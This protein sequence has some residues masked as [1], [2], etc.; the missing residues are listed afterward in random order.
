MERFKHQSLTSKI[1]LL[2]LRLKKR[3][4]QT[5]SCK[6]SCSSKLQ[7]HKEGLYSNVSYSYFYL[8]L[9]TFTSIT[10][11]LPPLYS[12]LTRYDFIKGNSTSF[13]SEMRLG[14]NE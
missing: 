9:A 8:H 1:D 3:K 4:T 13:A 11:S 10:I 7:D 2:T 12:T 14:K 6:W 5:K